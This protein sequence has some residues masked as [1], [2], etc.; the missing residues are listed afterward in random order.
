M[1]IPLFL[2]QT[3]SELLARIFHK[4]GLKIQKRHLNENVSTSIMQILRIQ[5]ALLVLDAE[6]QI[7]S[8]ITS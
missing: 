3:S 1:M 6:I 4:G 5:Y 8:D 7:Q 2:V